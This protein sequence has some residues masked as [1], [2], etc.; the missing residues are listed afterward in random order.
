VFSGLVLGG[1]I[2]RRDPQTHKRF[3]LCATLLML[4]PGIGRIPLPST[5][6]FGGEL[7]TLIAFLLA[8]PL[9][10]WDFVQ[11][12]R[13][14]LATLIGLGALAAEQLVRLAIWRSEPWLEAAGF[15]VGALT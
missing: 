5:T 3:M 6:I 11:R 7:T 8:T 12:G 4:Q 1:Y 9:L 14:H 13:P 15:I 2:Y 10:A